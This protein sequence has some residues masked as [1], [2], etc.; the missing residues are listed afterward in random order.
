MPKPSPLTFY[1]DYRCN[2]ILLMAKHAQTASSRKDVC[3]NRSSGT[4]E[5]DHSRL[6]SIIV[7][8]VLIDN[9]TGCIFH[10][11][12]PEKT[13]FLLSRY[14]RGRKILIDKYLKALASAIR[15]SADI[16]IVSENAIRR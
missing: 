15:M 7:C 14:R 6:Q 3:C 12:L 11:P 9:S 10:S 16:L 2:K 13:Y 8:I 5:Q 4:E 1:F